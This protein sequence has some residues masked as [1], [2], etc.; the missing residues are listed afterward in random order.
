MSRQELL[1]DHKRAFANYIRKGIEGD[2]A[3]LE[4][5]V[6]EENEGDGGYLLPPDVYETLMARLFQQSPMRNIAKVTTISS[7]A[8]DYLQTD[9]GIEQFK[10]L[11]IEAYELVG[12]PKATQRLIDDS[13]LDIFA[14]LIDKLVEI[15][16]RKENQAFINGDGSGKP[17]GIL[18]GTICIEGALDSDSI[19]K[20]YYELPDEFAKNATFLMNR[21]TAQYVRLLKDGTDQYLWNP[22]LALG[23]TDTLMGAPV[24][25][26][27]DMPNDAI[28][29][30]DFKYSYQIVDKFGIRILRDPYTEKPFVKFYST[31]RVGGRIVEAN[32][33]RVL[34]IKK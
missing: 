34:K 23:V 22:G 29:I 7:D 31:K 10:P 24:L 16:A 17:S 30:S 1:Q 9:E 27:S 18:Q 5:G 4:K 3:L 8:L 21:S 26:A 15:F 6:Y 14:W 28:A 19:I 32:A 2:L 12:Q 25:L 11:S 13:E 33:I 20:L